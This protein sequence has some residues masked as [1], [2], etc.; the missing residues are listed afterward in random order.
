M[1]IPIGVDN[2]DYNTG[3][4]GILVIIKLQVRT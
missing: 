1:D 4:R 2:E 3:Y